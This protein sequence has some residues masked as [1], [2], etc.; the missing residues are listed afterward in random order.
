MTTPI[1]LTSISKFLSLVLRHQPQEIGLVLDPAGWAR[2]DELLQKLAAAGWPVSMTQ[3][4]EVVETNDKKRFT[5]NED[6]SLIRAS[7]G[8]SIA[9]D[10]DLPVV[11]PPP[12]LY[13]GTATRFLAAI[14]S[15]G[16]DRRSRQHVHLTESVDTALSVGSRYG[17]PVLLKIDVQRMVSAGHQFRC[18]AN[19]VWLVDGV[20]PEFIQPD[21]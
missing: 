16:L 6:E 7:Q 10:L 5:F 21:A 15:E 12:V 11:T 17:A 9:I 19:G 18:S 13:H 20:P 2:V 1:K 3:L 8:H 4:R 14:M